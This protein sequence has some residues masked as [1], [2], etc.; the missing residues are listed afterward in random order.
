M[1]ETSKRAA[2]RAAEKWYDQYLV[3]TGI[4]IG[5]GDDPVTGTCGKWDLMDGDAELM[6]GLAPESF[7]WVY[8]SHCLE[9]VHHPEV[10]LARWWELVKP[11][12]YLIVMVP[13]EDLYE[14]GLWPPHFNT[15]HKSTW[16]AWKA[17][18]W[19]AASRNLST[20][21]KDLPGGRLVSLKLYDT[22]YDYSLRQKVTANVV[23]SNVELAQAMEKEQKL[24]PEMLAKFPDQMR[25]MGF[26]PIDQTASPLCAEV[27]LEGIVQKDA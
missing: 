23:L 24:T 27:S 15:D 26:W 17:Q 22:R 2:A 13:D 6:A 11:G 5:C 10:A 8:S 18:S 4:D 16:T 14:Q 1:G 3:G 9:H 19:S 21:I 20:L 25:L 7:D 12:G